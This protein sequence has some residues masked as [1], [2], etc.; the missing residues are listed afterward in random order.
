MSIARGTSATTRFKSRGKCSC[1]RL[2]VATRRIFA[3][4]SRSFASANSQVA[5][6]TS[7]ERARLRVTVS[8]VR[9]L[10]P[11]RRLRREN[12]KRTPAS[13]VREERLRRRGF[14]AQACSPFACVYVCMRTYGRDILYL[15][16]KSTYDSIEI[17]IF[18]L[19]ASRSSGMRRDTRDIRKIYLSGICVRI[20]Y[21][22]GDSSRAR[23]SEFQGDGRQILGI[24]ARGF[25][26]PR[27]A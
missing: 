22:F 10:L 14:L 17:L 1:H 8:V 18:D 24:L 16:A 19:E 25:Q 9:A 2:T 27:A 23:G 5:Q 20:N 6:D 4:L 13:R 21:T 3:F 7:S 12:R 11:H 26:R 15:R